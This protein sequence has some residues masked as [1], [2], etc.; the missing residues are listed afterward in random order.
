METDTLLIQI[1]QEMQEITLQ[2]RNAN[3]NIFSG[4]TTIITCICAL[5]SVVFAWK[6]VKTSLTLFKQSAQHDYYKIAVFTP[7]VEALDSLVQEATSH[8]EVLLDKVRDL[9]T[10]NAGVKDLQHE[11]GSG[12]KELQAICLSFGKIVLNHV[13]TA[14]NPSFRKSVKVKLEELEDKLAEGLSGYTNPD[15]EFDYTEIIREKVADIKNDIVEHDPVSSSFS[16]A[17]NGR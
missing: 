13:S 4:V 10:E 6:S 7:A 12:V 11:I 16:N 14:K 9:M 8:I 17:R 5:L 1:L 15:Y 2:S 3:S